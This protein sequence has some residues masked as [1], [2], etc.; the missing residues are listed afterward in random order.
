[1]HAWWMIAL[2]Y[3][4]SQMH[5]IHSCHLG[6][7]LSLKGQRIVPKMSKKVEPRCE[8]TENKSMQSIYT[9]ARL[10][11]SSNRIRRSVAA[12]PTVSN[13]RVFLSDF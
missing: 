7:N 12:G 3:N 8:R 4:Y 11:S 9:L 1:M 6:L 2:D 13:L 10:A 5:T